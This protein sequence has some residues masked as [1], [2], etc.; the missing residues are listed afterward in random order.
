[1]KEM[2]RNCYKISDIYLNNLIGIIGFGTMYRIFN[3]A[4][5]YSWHLD[6]L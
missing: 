6:N 5:V 2:F 1:M 3:F 4:T